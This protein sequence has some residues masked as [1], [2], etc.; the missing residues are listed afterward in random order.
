MENFRKT[1]GFGDGVTPGANPTH[2]VSNS[3]K[4]QNLR[5][6]TVTTNFVKNLGV[7]NVFGPPSLVR[8]LVYT[9]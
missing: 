2:N 7:T 5:C 4:V 1:P 3:G 8:L 6:I 9:I